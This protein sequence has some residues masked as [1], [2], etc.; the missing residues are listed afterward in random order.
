MSVNRSQRIDRIAKALETAASLRISDLADVFSVS[1]MTI[2]RDVA[3]QPE[4]FICRGGH[5]IGVQPG[6]AA[7]GYVLDNER[8]VHASGKRAACELAFRY[9]DPGDTVF[10]DCGTTMPHLA[11]R[12]G[13]VKDVTVIT[14]A[15]NIAEI[16]RYF[17]QVGLVL[18]GGFYQRSS[19]SFESPE[20][21]D[22]LRRIRINKAF[23]SAGGLHPEQGVSCS[24]FHEVPM[25]QEAIRRALETFLVVDS[26]KFG[27]V[28]PAYFADVSAFDAVLTDAGADP[29]TTAAVAA[30][31]SPVK[32]I[33]SAT[34]AE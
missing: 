24:N 13:D 23:I 9:V 21:L 26:S 22:I 27:R 4:R 28:R 6:S 12:L 8:E 7:L 10:I 15:M 29:Q 30:A 32:T 25:K 5:V 2:R 34:L 19:A 1:E 31:G 20:S 17:D 3:A 14:Y 33:S 18:L 11:R 16:V